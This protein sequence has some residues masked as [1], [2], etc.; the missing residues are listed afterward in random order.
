MTATGSEALELLRETERTLLDAVDA[1]DIIGFAEKP[2]A[3]LLA[4][5]VRSG[6]GLTA[7]QGRQAW[8]LLAR[9]PAGLAARGLVLPGTKQPVAPPESPRGCHDSRPIELAVRDTGRI[10]IRYS[11]MAL[12]EAL[13]LGLFAQFHKATKADP[14]PT[15]SVPASPASA[16]GLLGLLEGM[17]VRASQRVRDLADAHVARIAAYERLHPDH[18]LPSLDTRGLTLKPLWDHQLRGVDFATDATACLLGFPMGGGKALRLRTPI[19][20][21]SGWTTMGE[22]RDGDE[23]FDERGEVCRVVTAHPVQH[24]LPCY[25]VVFS[26]GER[27]IASGDHLWWTETRADRERQRHDSRRGGGVRTTEEIAASLRVGARGL[28]NHSV[29]IAAPLSLP[30]ADLPV[31]PYVLGQWLGGGHV[32]D[33]RITAGGV[34]DERDAP[35]V[36]ELIKAEGYDCGPGRL[37]AETFTVYGLAAQLRSLGALG[38]KHIPPVYLR[39][40][41]RQ[42]RALLAGLLDSDGA[43]CPHGRVEFDSTR[44]SLARGYL[45]LALS[46]GYRATITDKVV[47]L[48]GHDHGRMWRVSFMTADPVFRLPRKRRIHAERSEACTA[49]RDDARFIV[50]V[51]P[52]PTEPVRCIA[53]DSPSRL[54]LAG[55]SLI[56]THNTA[57]AIA[58]ANRLEVQRGIIVCPNKVR[59]VW[60]RE[61]AKWSARSWHI[62]DGRRPPKRKGARF[63]DLHIAERVHETE[64]ALFDCTCGAQAHFAV[65]NYEM[66]MHAPAATWRPPELLDIAIYDE[67]HRAKSP[68]GTMSKNLAEWVNFTKAR[69]G[70]TGTPMPQYPWD[71]FGVYRALEPGIFGTL[72][73]PF[74]SRFVFERETKEGRA[75]PVRIKG[76]TRAEFAEKVHS[77]M[78]RP[79]VDLKLPGREHVRRYVELEPAARKEYDSL[80]KESWA[81]LSAFA[82]GWPEGDE[83]LSPKNILSRMV[84]LMQFTG[85]TVPDD[86]MVTSKGVSGA[87]HRVSRAKENALAEFGPKA[88]RD[89]TYGIT[90]GVLD[91]IGCVPGHPGGPEPVVVYAQFTDDLRVI[92]EVARRAGLRYGEISGSRSDGLT[93]S[94]EMNPDID[95]C[96]VQIQAGGTGVDLTRA[97]FGVWYSKGHSLGDYDQALAR[98]DR[99]G[100]TRPV[101]FI[102]LLCVNTVD[103]DV[104]ESLVQR[105]S[106]IAV[107][108]E[109]RGI[110]PRAF[111]V[112]P[113]AIT[114]ALS[115]PD[116]SGRS[117]GVVALPIDEFGHDVMRPRLAHR[118]HDTDGNVVADRETLA[119]FDLEDF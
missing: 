107:S 103:E 37:P 106:L 47:K 100:Q 89:G 79:T 96:G 86:E 119:A 22:L 48:N 85:G 64:Q 115:L 57:T 69:I 80:D 3:A 114:P 78:Y 21:P 83:T 13:K 92:R 32:G 17:D 97:R 20:T 65:W 19:P 109:R 14:V 76:E 61:V 98:Q 53:V 110:D 54:F 31:P 50:D 74:K 18:P 77:I 112:D 99:P 40:S 111:G 43:V 12:N 42:R 7:D 72:W 15:W 55:R 46:L 102:H 34:G 26:D 23:L 24:G 60:P 117:G 113:G 27:I 66:L 38:D 82:D 36:R 58:A 70:L 4:S 10:G 9:N 44:E 59:G 5:H 28:T 116:G 73:Q 49:S 67:V 75:F 88:R 81:D 2:L 104:D 68:T 33:G 35:R 6:R 91:E 94:S 1:G 118:E 56:P 8:R 71:I 29:R 52:V 16:A 90:G 39:A 30:E 11:P 51:R 95:I 93:E 41:E 105:R 101:V 108:S 63:Q 45:E 62:V 84:R 25:E 87:K